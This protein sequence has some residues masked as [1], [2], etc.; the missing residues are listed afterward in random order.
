MLSKYAS[1]AIVFF[2]A[3][4]EP[5]L[6]PGPASAAEELRKAYHPTGLAVSANAIG[7]RWPAGARVPR[8][9]QQPRPNPDPGAGHLEEGAGQWISMVQKVLDVLESEKVKQVGIRIVVHIPLDM[10]HAEMARLMFGSFL[11]PIEEFEQVIDDP[12]D[13]LLQINGRRGPL[14]CQ[15]ILTAANKTQISQGVLQVPNMEAFLSERFLDT[16]VK[17]FHDRIS[18]SDSLVFD[19]NLSRK[20]VM[21]SDLGGFPEECLRAADAIGE[22][23]WHGC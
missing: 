12:G 10:S 15:I 4:F 17:D 20:G 18:S 13:P 1:R 6:G 3:D 16:G 9:F 23:C 11:V 2:A 5:V 21:S 7:L 19:V 22:A 14:E 8:S